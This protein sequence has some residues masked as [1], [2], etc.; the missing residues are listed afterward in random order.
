MKY[1]VILLNIYNTEAVSIAATTAVPAPFLAFLYKPIGHPQLYLS[2]ANNPQ[3][4][5]M[6]LSEMDILLTANKSPNPNLTS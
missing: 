5:R 3:K 2:L 1:N 6:A 4:Y